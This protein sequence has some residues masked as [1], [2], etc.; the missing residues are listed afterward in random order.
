MNPESKYTLS[1]L[2]DLKAQ[3]EFVIEQFE[4]GKMR[5]LDSRLCGPNRIGDFLI[6]DMKEYQRGTPVC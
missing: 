5:E 2:K 6:T 4:A 1:R 3:V